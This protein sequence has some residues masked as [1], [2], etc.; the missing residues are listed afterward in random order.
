MGL[1]TTVQVSDEV[2]NQMEKLKLLWGV[3]SYDDVIKRMI[4]MQTGRAE[5]LFGAAKGSKPFH[6]E[7]EDEH[8][9]VR[10]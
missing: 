1:T 9:V 8:D 10:D 4:R 2:R 7:T 3:K 5:S 6:R